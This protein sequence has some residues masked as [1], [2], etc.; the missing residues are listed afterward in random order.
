MDL[1]AGLGFVYGAQ[2]NYSASVQRALEVIQANPAWVFPRDRT[3][4]AADLRLLLAADY[5]AE[6]NYV[7][8]LAQVVLLNSSFSANVSTVAGQRALG[9]EIERLRSVV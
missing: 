8:A 2:K 6:G 1:R 5:F 3:I 7:A 9:E 4:S